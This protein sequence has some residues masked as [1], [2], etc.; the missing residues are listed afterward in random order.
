[1]HRINFTVFVLITSILLHSCN[2]NNSQISYLDQNLP[3]SKPRLFSTNIVNTDS[4]EINSVF[5]NSF[6]EVFFTRIIN[7]SFVIHNSEL[8]D[9]HWTTPQPIQMFENK[10][11]KSVAIDPTI[12]IDGKT[13]YFLGIS[14][15]DNAKK[16]KT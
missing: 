2:S 9:G 8:I 7:G 6:T 3:A 12:T 4:I 5:N 16:T 13:M 11:D 10:I 15:E 14:P 1:M